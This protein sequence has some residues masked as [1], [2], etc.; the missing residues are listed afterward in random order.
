MKIRKYPDPVL[1]IKSEDINESAKSLKNVIKQ[2]T[3]VMKYEEGVGL[4]GNQI[5]I[6]KRIIIIDVNEKPTVMIN[7]VIKD[8]SKEKELQYEGCL[9][10]PNFNVIV[11]RYKEIDGEFLNSSGVKESIHLEGLYA[12]AFQHEIDHLN[13]V[14]IIDYA[15]PEDRFNYNIY[16][17]K[18][19]D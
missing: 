15:S 11:E 18:E 10:F 4:A 8:H 13:G 19:K 12:R 5:G 2:M 16:I 6:T 14:L 9:S 3:N 7:P 17:T 1:R